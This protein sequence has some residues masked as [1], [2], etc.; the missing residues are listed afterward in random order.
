MSIST[1]IARLQQ[2]KSDLATSIANKGVTVPAATTIDGYAA[3]VD[4]IQ[5]GGGDIIGVLDPTKLETAG[6]TVIQGDSNYG[7]YGSSNA[8]RLRIKAGCLI[9]IEY[10]QTITFYGLKGVNC[11]LNALILCFVI[12]SS[13]SS[14]SHS[15]LIGGSNIGSSS[16]FPENESEL[17]NTYRW[18][19]NIGSGYLSFVSKIGTTDSNIN[20]SNYSIAYLIR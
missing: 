4:Q 11:N 6:I 20:I 18:A 5:T 10:G 19:N 13:N 9:P 15:T 14:P 1:E 12:Y 8:K 16:F 2:A 7:V 17:G 3:L